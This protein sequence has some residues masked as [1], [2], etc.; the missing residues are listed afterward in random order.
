MQVSSPH[1]SITRPSCCILWKIDSKYGHDLRSKAQWGLSLHYLCGV[2][3]C[4]FLLTSV[5]LPLSYSPTLLLE[6]FQYT[7]FIPASKLT[8]VLEVSPTYL[9]VC[10][11]TFQVFIEMGIPSRALTWQPY[12]S[13]PSKL[14]FCKACVTTYIVILV[15]LFP[16]L[17]CITWKR[18]N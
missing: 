13:N 15:F 7:N 12:V 6:I 3:A 11:F 5:H 4:S 2:I 9:W 1:S 10:L 17:E 18:G 16:L 14:F 8:L